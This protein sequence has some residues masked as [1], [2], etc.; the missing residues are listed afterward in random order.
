M[1]KLS[2]IIQREYLAKV[3]N[4]SFVIMTFLSPILMVGM[5]VLISYLTQ[6]N[7]SEKRIVALMNESNY[8]QTE[9]V[10]DSRISYLH[11]ENIEL[12]AA[13]DSVENMGFTGLLYLPEAENLQT[14]AEN[15]VFYSKDAPNSMVLENIEEIFQAGLRENRLKEIGL[16]D[17]EFESVNDQYEIRT[18]TAALSCVA[19]SKRRPAGSLR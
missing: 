1:S 7:D 13:K 8:F 16:S 15:A 3:R 19:L 2:L 9:F 14:V 12:S 6:I 18:S 4:K 5:I 17:E 11:Y 10:A